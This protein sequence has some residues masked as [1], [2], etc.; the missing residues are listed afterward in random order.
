MFE[1]IDM[2]GDEE[3][4][5]EELAYTFEQFFT[6]SKMIEKGANKA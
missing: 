3:I 6:V 1:E 2:N 4:E 5:E